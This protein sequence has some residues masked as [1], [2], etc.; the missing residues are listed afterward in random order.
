MI[1]KS[2]NYSK[3][4][5]NETANNIGSEFIWFWI[6]IEPTN[7]EILRL[8]IKR[9]KYICRRTFLFNLSEGYSKHLVSTDDGTWYLYKLAIFWN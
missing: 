8:Y 7:K 1:I 6:A 5:V 9:T 4:T 2:E 3:F